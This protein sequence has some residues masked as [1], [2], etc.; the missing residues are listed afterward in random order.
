MN[1]NSD[2]NQ[3]NE[4]ETDPWIKEHEDSLDYP[5]V[6]EDNGYSIDDS[7][8]SSEAQKAIAKRRAQIAEKTKNSE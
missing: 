7:A 2:K 1:Q 8:L 5:D 3:G 6:P 4:G